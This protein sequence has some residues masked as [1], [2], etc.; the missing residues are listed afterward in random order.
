M[1]KDGLNP[2]VARVSRVLKQHDGLLR[3]LGRCTDNPLLV[4]I[5]HEGSLPGWASHRLGAATRKAR[6]RSHCCRSGIPDAVR[7]VAFK[8]GLD[9]RLAVS[10]GQGCPADN[11]VDGPGCYLEAV[12]RISRVVW[13]MKD[14]GQGHLAALRRCNRFQAHSASPRISEV[15]VIG[16]R[17]EGKDPED[18]A[19]GPG[20][21]KVD[22]TGLRFH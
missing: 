18:L 1:P 3:R 17:H 5:G 21:G 20:A 13:M 9:D 10:P 4:D 6:V 19:C 12:D 7:G 14:K 16:A 22:L 15:R 2:R 11:V 8:P